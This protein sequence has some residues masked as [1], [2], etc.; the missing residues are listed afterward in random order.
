VGAQKII[1][2]A[3]YPHKHC[4]GRSSTWTP[5]RSSPLIQCIC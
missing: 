1:V 2:A 3:Q 5:K 4:W